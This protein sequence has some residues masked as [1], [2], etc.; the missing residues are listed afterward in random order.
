MAVVRIIAGK[1]RGRQI[2]VPA[3]AATR[4]YA[5]RMRSAVFDALGAQLG[6]PGKL[7]PIAVL[8]LYAGSGALGFE[9][10]S[11]GAAYCTFVESARAAVRQL[12]DNIK[13][14]DAGG[15]AQV[16]ALDVARC[17][18]ETLDR[19]IDLVFMDPPFAV[20][21]APG[22]GGSVPAV[23]DRLRRS[24]RL[25]AGVRIGVRHEAEIRSDEYIVAGFT[26]TDRRTYG[27][28]CI[29]WLGMAGANGEAANDVG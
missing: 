28:S 12:R 1:W 11:R 17:A 26:L 29:T 21:A 20:S 10:L 25:A 23:L 7:P 2:E 19:A 27:R 22:S 5:D 18:F 6:T 14:L 4:P 15:Q 13:T 16:I 24:G 9:A 3:V 8:D